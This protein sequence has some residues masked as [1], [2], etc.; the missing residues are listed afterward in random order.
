MFV[1]SLRERYIIAFHK[2]ALLSLTSLQNAL[3]VCISINTFN[4][5]MNSTKSIRYYIIIKYLNTPMSFNK[6]K[7]QSLAFSI[8]FIKK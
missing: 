2:I 7:I 8:K 5:S 3:C 6:F 4:L 1:V